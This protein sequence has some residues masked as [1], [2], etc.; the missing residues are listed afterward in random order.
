MRVLLTEGSG[1]TSRQVATRL[2]LTG[3][4]VEILSSTPVCLSRFTRHVRKVH[5]V[6]PFGRT[7]LAWLAAADDIVR[8]RKIDVLFPTQEQVTVLAARPDVLGYATV[9]PEFA[10]LLRVQDKISACKTLEAAGIPQPP[11]V[12]IQDNDGLARVDR[13][14]V[15]VKRPV[16]TASS[17]VRR[18]KDAGELRTAASALGLGRQELVVQQQ[19]IG[20]LAM[21]QAVADHGRLVAHHAN[22]R[23]QEGIGGGA[24]IKESIVVPRMADHLQT[25]VAHLRWHGPI[26][27]DVILTTDGPVVIDINPRLVEPM[28]AH[29][30]GVDLVETMLSLAPRRTVTPQPPGRPGIRSHQLL[31]AVLGAAEAQA[32]RSAVVRELFRALR[33][34]GPYAGSVEEL[35][36][37]EGDLLSA[38]PVL[39]ATLA[40]LIWPQAWRLFHRGAVGSYALTPEAW[41]EIVAFASCH[42]DLSWQSSASRK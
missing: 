37:I 23:V 18:A 24:A 40:T 10:A 30:A 21:V 38:V 11:T 14:P 28:N 35:T 29:L 3:H 9:V 5:P 19:C 36:P 39:A 41:A 16:S 32:S 17:G 6:P 7:P 15:F 22:S 8:R 42:Q 25:L 26:S 27:L 31:L 33:K 13:F 34:A 4:H 12:L 1:L 20:P 2:G